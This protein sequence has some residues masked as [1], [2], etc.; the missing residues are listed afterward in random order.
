[1]KDDVQQNFR[2]EVVLRYCQARDFH[3]IVEEAGAKKHG[4]MHHR[5]T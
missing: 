1:M 2:V 4:I 5:V 3:L